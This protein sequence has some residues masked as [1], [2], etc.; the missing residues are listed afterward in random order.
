MLYRRGKYFHFDFTVAGK[1][2]RGSTQQTAESAARKVES[3][4][5]EKAEQNGSSAVLRRAPLLSVFGPRFLKW[6]NEGRGL[7]HNTRRYYRLGWK[8]ISE[9]PLM[10]M[11]LD[12]IT[13]EEVDGLQLSGSPS[14]VNQ[15]LRTLRRALGKAE[16]WK[17]IT[18]ALRIALLEEKERD[19]IL[20]SESEAKLLAVGKQPLNDVLFIAQ[21]TGLRP[22]EVFRVRIEHVDFLKRRIFNPSGKTRAS[23]RF[24]PISQRM[25]SMLLLRCAGKTEGWPSNDRGKAI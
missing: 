5:I 4:L 17:V 15:V 13:T 1:R 21:D 11:M 12:R 25:E 8:R 9:T 18:K 19:E 16:E 20:D 24:V 14:Y 22:E 7:A 23:R 2:F 10:G 6:I 3:K